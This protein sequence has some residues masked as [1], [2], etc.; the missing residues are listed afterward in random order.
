MGQNAEL[1]KRYEE[2]NVLPFL[3]H[4]GWGENPE[5]MKGASLEGRQEEVSHL[6]KDLG[7]AVAS[8][9]FKHGPQPSMRAQKELEEGQ[10]QPATSDAFHKNHLGQQH[11]GLVGPEPA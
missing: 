4:Q 2:Y 1:S 3:D 11:K 7:K 8:E 9:H 6:M 5:G 10:K